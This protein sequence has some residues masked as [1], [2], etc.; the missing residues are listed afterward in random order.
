MEGTFIASGTTINGKVTTTE[1]IR[2]DGT[3]KGD[4]DAQGK[5]IVGTQGVVEGVLKSQHTEISGNLKLEKINAQTLILTS[6]ANFKGDIEVENL[7]V[8]SGAIV[9][10]N[11]KM[12]KGS[13]FNNST[14][15]F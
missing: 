1:D 9:E 7:Q 11:I 6:S 12:T 8:D 4:I 3:I 13:S 5:L 14:D 10:G 15:S 2:I